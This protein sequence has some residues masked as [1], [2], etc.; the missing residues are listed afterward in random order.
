MMLRMIE[1][2]DAKFVAD[3]LQLREG[4][5]DAQRGPRTWNTTCTGLADAAGGVSVQGK[6]GK[7]TRAM[8][9]GGA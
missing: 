1:R 9:K 8:K 2:H 7:D 5:G 3:A 4:G 6:A